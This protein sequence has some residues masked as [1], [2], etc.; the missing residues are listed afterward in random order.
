MLPNCPWSYF[1]IFLQKLYGFSIFVNSKH[2]SKNTGMSNLEFSTFAYASELVPEAL[3]SLQI[4][5]SHGN[6]GKII[7]ISCLHRKP[8]CE[9]LLRL[10]WA[11]DLLRFIT[12]NV[13]LSESPFIDFCRWT[14]N[15]IQNYKYR[16]TKN[17][18]NSFKV[19]K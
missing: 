8:L 13:A 2:H 1:G 5:L 14:W 18:T 16:F 19:K 11:W 15:L 10:A 3:F 6:F 12:C 17:D 4:L 9:K 7:I